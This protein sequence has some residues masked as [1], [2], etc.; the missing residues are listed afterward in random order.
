MSRT[1]G[2]EIT[3]EE[4]KV[5]LEEADEQ[6]GL[7][8]RDIVRL[9]TEG[10][11]PDLLQEIF[12]AAHTLKGSS[13]M[14]GHECMAE[15]THAMESLLDGLRNRQIV[16]NAEVID[17][18]LYSLDVLKTLEEDLASC[19]DGSLVDISL[20]VARLESATERARGV[21]VPSLDMAEADTVSVEQA[22]K[23]ESA[24]GNSLA[25]TDDDHGGMTISANQGGRTSFQSVRVDVRTLDN[26]MNMVEELVIDRSRI[27]QINRVLESR[28]A[29]DELVRDLSQTSN[30]IVKVINELQQDIMQ[31]RMVQIGALFG[32]FPRL[33]RD[34][35]Q[36]Q[37]KKVEFVVEGEDTELDRNIIEHIRDPLIQLLRNAI[38]HGTENPEEREAAGKSLM[39]VVKLS[40]SQEEGHIVIS[41]E[42]DGRGI[43][44]EA[45]KDV[46]VRKG[47]ISAEEASRL[48]LTEAI[49][50]IFMPGVS[51][52][53][54]ITDVSGRGVGLDVVKAN[55]EKLNGV[56][57]TESEIGQGTKFIVTLP[58]TIAL[59]QGLMVSVNKTI[60][61]MPLTFVTE[62]MRIEPQKIE[63][64]RGREVIR[65]R[66]HIVPLLRIDGT[67]CM[68]MNGSSNGD[69]SFVVVARYSDIKV[70][71][72]VDELMEQQEFVVKPLSR[73]L[74]DVRGLAG[75]TILGDGQVALIVDIPTL[76]RISAYQ[77]QQGVNSAN[78]LRGSFSSDNG[79]RLKNGK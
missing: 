8:D 38:D 63:T 10:D 28:Y 4:M 25:G 3:R 69:K 49:N 33:V 52:T 31:V 15:L 55:I 62:T 47:L 11:N 75:A 45:V 26:L 35:T 17:S 6:I 39:A 58:L 73:Y 37:K 64:I 50:L 20:A 9:E 40:A 76:V 32:S 30:H 5:F 1:T 43:D 16:V 2:T 51:T 21:V 71:I 61:V 59:I 29:G 13:A 12:R 18:L 53:E 78:P 48:S 72:I 27:S 7:L 57:I 68:K 42:D 14:L 24:V 56:I 19:K 23:H 36:K 22:G 79:K 70:G 74:C 67:P 44:I 60:Y 66:D 54:M 77:R 65:V 34:L 41:V 46:S